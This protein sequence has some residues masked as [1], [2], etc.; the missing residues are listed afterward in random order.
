MTATTS[1]KILTIDASSLA[2]VVH[3]K[4]AIE[5]TTVT[6][7]RRFHERVTLSIPP[8]AHWPSDL[9]VPG[10]ETIDLLSNDVE[11]ELL[12][13]AIDRGKLRLDDTQNGKLRE[14]S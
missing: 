10:T 7:A 6:Y 5:A 4:P 1:C 13:S 12:Q 2:E 14:E 9:V 3:M 11:L 8:H